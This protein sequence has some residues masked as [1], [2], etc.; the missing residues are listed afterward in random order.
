MSFDYS[1]L[2]AT[3]RK[4]LA[5]FGQAMTVS[6]SVQGA[7]DPNTGTTS[8]T[9]TTFT[10][11]GVI[12]PIRDSVSN[13]EGSLIQMDDQQIFFQASQAPIPTD[14]ITVGATVYN[15]VA[16]KPMEPGG[17]NVLYELLVRK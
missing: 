4:L 16:V 9:T 8:V 17:V 15:V 10:D 11:N 12:F 7:Y 3:A 13:M 14:Q 6:R 2:L 1:G 5:Q